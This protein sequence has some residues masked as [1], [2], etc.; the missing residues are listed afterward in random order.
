MDFALTP[1]QELIRDSAGD[2][3]ARELARPTR[4]WDRAEDTDRPPAPRLAD[5]GYPGAGWDEEYGGSGLDVV[6]YALVVEE[7]GKVD[8]SVRGIVS[9]NVGLVGKTIA[10]FGTD[11]QRRAWLPRLAS[12]EALG[13]YALTEP[14]CGS[15]AAALVTRAKRDGDDWVLTG[16]KT[17][18][19]LGNWASV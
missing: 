18:I 1:E 15:D 5:A 8:S 19:T 7:L 13:C 11:E 4:E 17:F 14:G 9:V 3:A 6:S 16:S 2:F 12:G 10:R